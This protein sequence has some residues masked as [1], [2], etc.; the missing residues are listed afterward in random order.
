MS[1]PEKM[2][3]CPGCGK[4]Y[5]THDPAEWHCDPGVCKD[6]RPIAKKLT[7]FFMSNIIS[8]Q[9]CLQRALAECDSVHNL[10]PWHAMFASGSVGKC[11]CGGC[12]VKK[13]IEDALIVFK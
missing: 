8:A 5:F 4:P 2:Y 11:Q 12:K 13:H 3:P 7:A 6:C 9:D 1:E 10:R